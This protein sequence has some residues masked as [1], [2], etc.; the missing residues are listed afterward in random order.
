MGASPGYSEPGLIFRIETRTNF[1]FEL[2]LDLEPGSK[3][4]FCVEPK[5][6]TI[7]EKN[8]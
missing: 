1:C 8:Y 2:E 7:H 6:G 3:F 4:H 5:T